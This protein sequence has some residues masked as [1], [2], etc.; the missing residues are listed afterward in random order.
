MRYILDVLYSLTLLLF[1]P[2]LLYKAL[3]TGKYRRGLGAKLLGLAPPDPDGRCCAWFHGVSVGEIHLL[4]Q[5]VARFRQRRPEI[6]ADLI[7]PAEGE[8]GCEMHHAAEH[9]AAE[10]PHQPA[11][12]VHGFPVMEGIGTSRLAPVATP[13][14][15]S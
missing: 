2:W 10:K 4:R 5:V 3:T 6:G 11:D 12:H 8:H 14:G 15:V 7:F 1:F 9:D 13:T